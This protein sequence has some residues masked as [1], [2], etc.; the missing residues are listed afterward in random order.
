MATAPRVARWDSSAGGSTKMQDI[1]FDI[2]HYQGHVDFA[3]AYAAGMRAVI[4]KA[5]EGLKYTDPTFNRNVIE[6][7]AAGLLVGA[8]HFGT[9]ATSGLEQAQHFLSVVGHNQCLTVL[10]FEDSTSQMSL[11]EAI[12]FVLEIQ[13]ETGVWPV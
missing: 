1:I 9:G 8:Y 12:E 11:V 5:T 2:S 13:Q 7:Q 4:V 6:A 3:A 10:D